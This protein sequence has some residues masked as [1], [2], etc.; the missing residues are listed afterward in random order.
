MAGGF[1]LKQIE[2]LASGGH[3]VLGE[4]GQELEGERLGGPGAWE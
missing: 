2:E 3:P 4:R 1:R